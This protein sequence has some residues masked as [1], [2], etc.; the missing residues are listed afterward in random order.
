MGALGTRPSFSGLEVWVSGCGFAQLPNHLT[1]EP[2]NQRLGTDPKFPVC[3]TLPRRS[4]V[5][6]RAG[7]AASAKRQGRCDGCIFMAGIISKSGRRGKRDLAL[8]CDNAHETR[9]HALGQC[10]KISFEVYSCCP[11][12]TRGATRRRRVSAC[13]Q[14][15]CC[16]SSC[17]RTTLLH[18]QKRSRSTLYLAPQPPRI[19]P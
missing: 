10:R 12:N 19:I 17:Q 18:R 6:E 14:A 4:I 3:V 5:R 7:S 13:S 2:P 16:P 1:T 11:R 8:P 15:V 9:S